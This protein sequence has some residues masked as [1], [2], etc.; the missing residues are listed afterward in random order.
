MRVI[1]LAAAGTA[2]AV[3][4]LGSSSVV[5]GQEDAASED[6]RYFYGELEGYLHPDPDN[7]FGCEVGFTS[8]SMLFGES[9]LL[10][11]TTLRQLNCYVPSDTLNTAQ[12]G[13]WTITGESGDTL[14]G[15]ENGSGDCIPD[16]VHEPG[17]FYSCWGE[18]TI[19]GGTGAFEGATG[20]VHA[21]VYTWNSQS[22]HPDAAHGDTPASMIFEGLVEY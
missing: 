6:P 1:R 22:D 18:I 19:T 4:L 16:E 17:G 14:T 20:E 10:G 12:L 2:T 8:D 5:L 11:A 3:L 21:L 15:S 7:P 13:T 9:T